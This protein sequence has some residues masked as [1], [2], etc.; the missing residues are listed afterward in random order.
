MSLAFHLRPDSLKISVQDIQIWDAQNN[1]KLG[2]LF[3]HS[4]HSMLM[5]HHFRVPYT[6]S[7][8]CFLGYS[9][10]QDTPLLYSIIGGI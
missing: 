6:P 9:L 8:H 2:G 4:I 10:L 5:A 1:P 7:I 3:G